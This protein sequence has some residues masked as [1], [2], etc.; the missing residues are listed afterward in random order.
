MVHL[1]VES[2]GWVAIH[3]VQEV[4]PVAVCPFL[5]GLRL[6]FHHGWSTLA[7]CLDVR[8]LSRTDVALD[9]DGVGP[10]S[11]VLGHP[12]RRDK[13][14]GLDWSADVGGWASRFANHDFLKR[15]SR[16]WLGGLERTPFLA[17]WSVSFDC[18]SFLLSDDSAGSFALTSGV[19]IRV[20][21]GMVLLP[22]IVDPT[23]GLLS[24]TGSTRIFNTKAVGA[25]TE[26][27][28]SSHPSGLREFRVVTLLR[29]VFPR[30]ADQA[31]RSCSWW[32]SPH[33]VFELSCAV[34][35]VVE[36]SRC[37]VVVG[38]AMK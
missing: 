5:D 34:S 23:K 11:A 35:G 14:L 26:F 29:L 3:L 6:G 17:W 9:D 37:V 7:E 19:L 8:R 20:Q 15:F 38:N 12:W 24:G 30:I 33:G 31:A 13:C 18:F 10:E 25:D 1:E 27:L 16:L 2:R 4:D 21:G 32:M 22:A 36:V 28:A